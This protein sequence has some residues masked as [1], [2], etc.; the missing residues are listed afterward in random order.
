MEGDRP[1]ME[2]S[3][4][5]PRLGIIAG[6]TWPSGWWSYKTAAVDTDSW[7]LEGQPRLLDVCAVRPASL[8]RGSAEERPRNQGH[9]SLSG[10]PPTAARCGGT[11]AQTPTWTWDNCEGHP[12]TP[13]SVGLAGASWSGKVAR[14]CPSTS[15][16]PQNASYLVV[17]W[18]ET[19]L[20]RLDLHS[21]S[22]EGD[23]KGK[24]T[25]KYPVLQWGTH[26]KTD[27]IHSGAIILQLN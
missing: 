27:F 19:T 9:T 26:R 15:L 7:Y 8:G 13:T 25:R 6:S 17:P 21:V 3:L 23:M 1:A 24:G 11:K 22:G 5:S 20:R 18:S 14:S 10:S 16:C 12:S 2:G 4:G